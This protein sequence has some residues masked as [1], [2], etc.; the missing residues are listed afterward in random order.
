MDRKH[1]CFFSLLIF[2]LIFSTSFVCASDDAPYSNETISSTDLGSS[3]NDTDYKL[4]LEDSTIND[5]DSNEN[6]EGNK[7]SASSSLGSK[8]WKIVFLK[9]RPKTLK[10]KYCKL[11]QKPK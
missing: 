6:M 11:D 10:G 3:S 8:K 7:L 4:Y 5:D 9:R 2:I 1:I